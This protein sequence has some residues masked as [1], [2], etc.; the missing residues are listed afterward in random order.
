[1]EWW[2]IGV[3]GWERFEQYSITPVP[4]Y[5]IAIVRLG[6]FAFSYANLAQE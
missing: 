2:N 6:Q 1:M 4:Q 3:M 5:S